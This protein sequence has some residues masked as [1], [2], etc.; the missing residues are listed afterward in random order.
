ME[1]LLERFLRY[2]AV[3]T[4]SSYETGTHPSTKAQYDFAAM[5]AKELGEIGLSDVTLEDTGYVMA[6]LPANTDKALPVIGFIAHMDTSPDMTAEKVSPRVV[7]NYDGGKI[8]LNPDLNIILS[9]DEFPSLSRYAGCDLVVTDGTT[10]LGADDKAGIAEIVTAMEYLAGHPEIRH[11]RIRVC[12]TPDEEIGEGADRFDLERFGADF[13]YTMD[14]DELGSL[15]YENF[16]AA[17]AKIDIKGR[18]IHPGSAKNKMKNSILIAMELESLL[19]CSEKPAYTEGYE[20]FYHLNDIEGNVENTSMKYIIRD[21]DRKKFENRKLLLV[22]IVEF[23]NEKYG[24]G[25]VSVEIKD[26]Y[27]NMKE[28]VEPVYH[29]VDLAVRA[30]ESVGIKPA[31]KPIRGGTDGSRLSWMGLPTPNIFT[32]G[33]NFHG[34]YEFIPVES[35]EK[36]VEVILKIAELSAL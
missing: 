4:T 23:L 19:P 2:T 13:A 6:T 35:M 20:G 11:G 9:P 36:A 8:I 5:L 14:G 28:K 33:Q 31:I 16:N 22:K 3:C 27:Y 10:L 18:N 34:K 30:M 7:A 17:S 25:T 29:V 1:N 32:G 15:E 12:F 24:A 26:Q 21:H